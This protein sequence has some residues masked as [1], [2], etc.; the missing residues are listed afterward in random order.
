[1][2]AQIT[3]PVLPGQIG[4]P[5][6][7]GGQVVSRFIPAALTLF[8]VIGS[9]LFFAYLVWGAIEWIISGGDKQK[10]ESARSRITNAIIGLIILFATFAILRI[11]GA[12][13]HIDILTGLN[14][15]S[16]RLQP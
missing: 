5:G 15:E 9:I 3:N 8:F 2:L 7:S 1:M 12:F 16:L 10:L 4:N 13:F 11:I 6:E 14:F